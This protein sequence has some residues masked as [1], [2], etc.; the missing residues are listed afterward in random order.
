MN[1]SK[2]CLS[3]I[4]STLARGTAPFIQHGTGHVSVRDVSK[5]QPPDANEIDGN[6]LANEG[7]VGRFNQKDC[8]V[9]PIRYMQER[10]I[11]SVFRFIL[12]HP[13]MDHMDGMKALFEAFPP[14]NFWDS[15]NQDEKGDFDDQS[16]FNEEDWLFYKSC[17][18]IRQ[19]RTRRD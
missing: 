5:A 18:T 10:K 12:T 13:D 17:V 3:S 2:A 7:V 6:V 9:N 15:D 4:F 16:R 14:V 8:P 11:N 1:G 19:P